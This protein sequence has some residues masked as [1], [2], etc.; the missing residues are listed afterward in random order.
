MGDIFDLTAQTGAAPVEA[1]AGFGA[2]P[3]PQA[4]IMQL[5]QNAWNDVK[6]LGPGLNTIGSLMKA[7]AFEMTPAG[8]QHNLFRIF[9]EK[10]NFQPGSNDYLPSDPETIGRIGGAIGQSYAKN[11]VTPAYKALTGQG[12]VQDIF[13]YPLKHPLYA[14]LDL[15]PAA[16]LLGGEKLVNAIKG[17]QAV[18]NA[19]NAAKQGAATLGGKTLDAL[20]QSEHF[21][22]VTDWLGEK[23]ADMKAAK[24]IS[25]PL[26]R[27]VEKENQLFQSELKPYW[28]A[29]PPKLRNQVSSYAEGWHGNQ[30]SNMPTPPVIQA[31]LD[32]AR[33]ISK[34]MQ[35]RISDV[36]GQDEIL[37]S[38]YY[39][40]AARMY[41]H[42]AFKTLSHDAQMEKIQQVRAEMERR[43]IN[44]VY[45]PWMRSAEVRKTLNSPATLEGS[46]TKWRNKPGF[47]KKK[48]SDGSGFHDMHYDAIHARFL[49]V[50]KWQHAYKIVLDKAL[51]ASDDL[52][53]NT[54]S[55]ELKQAIKSGALKPVDAHTI[56]RTI[57][58]SQMKGFSPDEMASALKA[59]PG[60]VYLPQPMANALEKLTGNHDFFGTFGKILGTTASITRR[61]MLGLNPAYPEVQGIQNIAMLEF[62]QNNGPRSAWLSLNAWSL[63]ANA[64]IRALIPMEIAAS[65][66]ALEAGSNAQHL[67][68]DITKLGPVAKAME[69]S[70]AVEVAAKALNPNN[71]DKAVD[72]NMYRMSVYDNACRAKA[73]IQ[74]ALTYSEDFPEVGQLIKGVL[75]TTEA[76]ERLQLAFSK[77]QLVEQIS[78]GVNDVLGDFSRAAMNGPVMGPL[79]KVALFPAWYKVFWN[80][81][82]KLPQNNPYKTSILSQMAQQYPALFGDGRL[83]QWMQ[84]AG[85]VPLQGQTNPQ[86]APLYMG[87]SNWNP[88][89]TLVELAEMLEQPVSSTADSSV[90]T[91][92][93]PLLSLAVF[94]T[95]HK[96]P[97]SM[98]DYSDPRL[99][100]YDHKQYK[101]EDAAVGNFQKEQHPRPNL[102]E[103]AARNIFTYPTNIGERIFEK[104]MSGGE[105]S[106]MTSPISL[107]SAP[108]KIHGGNDILQAADWGS[109]ASEAATNTFPTAVDLEAEQNARHFD[110]TKQRKLKQAYFRQQMNQ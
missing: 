2:E 26:A 32:K 72:M 82:S 12:P 14:A 3:E 108:K 110:A 87:G 28:D 57:I 36:V 41:G 76:A 53:A 109:L 95:L 58:G 94:Y 47:L 48:T 11:Y 85:Y 5:P 31:Y 43:G 67:F 84:K 22:N 25:E 97:S 23:L 74:L 78:K 15:A 10:A 79:R 52:I 21:T 35:H 40:A 63:A 29:I 9:P 71:I 60:Q 66:Q 6:Q 93:N 61:Y 105:K 101:P 80:F 33:D 89:S 90:M 51:K 65:G 34:L 46:A 64:E 13:D 19:T 49:Q 54:A 99:V 8:G 7:R 86:G 62:V 91:A 27:R 102:V 69:K 100:K 17:S 1:P 24:E 88:S 73:A 104:L 83:P 77:P 50:S 44:P 81:A 4:D 45:S 106:Q 30:W 107:E 103:L 38:A 42:D 18:Q 39:P 68:G 70:K 16:K 20:N 37:H 96:N 55:E 59:L 75:S 56:Y 92:I 98:R